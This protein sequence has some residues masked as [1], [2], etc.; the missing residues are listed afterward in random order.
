MQI[1]QRNINFPFAKD[2]QLDE[3]KNNQLLIKSDFDV[4]FVVYYVCLRC[5]K[6]CHVTNKPLKKKNVST[7]NGA[8]KRVIA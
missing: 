6:S 4:E 2:D 5:F 7:D 1:Q 3:K 8:I